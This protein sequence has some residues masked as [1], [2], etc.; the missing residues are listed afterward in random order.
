M[1]KY[2]VIAIGASA[3]GI[4]AVEMVLASLNP[5]FKIPIVFLIHRTKTKECFLCDILSRDAHYSSV[6][7]VKDGSQIK[8]DVVYIAPSERHVLVEGGRFLLSDA[9]RVNFVRPSIDVLFESVAREYGER[10]IAVILT[11]TGHDGGEGV[12]KIKEAGGVTIAQDEET[13]YH[14]SMPEAAIA[15]G[16]VDYVIPID[17]IANLIQ[18]LVGEG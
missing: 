18:K 5:K 10:A 7:E 14:F 2:H 3:G 9:D 12:R 1:G 4:R 11:G 16:C 17:E 8:D 6:E 13:S 15:T